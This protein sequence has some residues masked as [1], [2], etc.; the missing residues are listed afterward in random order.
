MVVVTY[1]KEGS[2]QGKY[3]L[4]K[5][6]RGDAF[7]LRYSLYKTHQTINQ[8]TPNPHRLSMLSL[9]HMMVTN[10]GLSH[11][12]AALSRSPSLFLSLSLRLSLALS[13][14]RSSSRGR[15]SMKKP[16]CDGDLTVCLLVGTRAH[17]W[18]ACEYNCA[19]VL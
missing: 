9:E 8:L 14:S 17:E 12:V 15:V 1:C 16:A 4:P 6:A 10:A 7:T 19:T 18:A 5:V 11:F 13:N 3:A 2:Q